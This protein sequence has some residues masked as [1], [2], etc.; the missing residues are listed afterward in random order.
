MIDQ[1]RSVLILYLTSSTTVRMSVKNVIIKSILFFCLF[2]FGTKRTHKIGLIY[3]W[4]IKFIF[5]LF[6]RFNLLFIFIIFISSFFFFLLF[7][8]KILMNN[9]L[10]ILLIHRRSNLC[11]SNGIIWRNFLR[12]YHLKFFY[13]AFWEKLF[14]FWF[15]VL[16]IQ[17]SLFA[18]LILI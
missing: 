16:W 7:M 18:I 9:N 11:C 13:F 3:F 10:N 1:S 12:T 14:H 8:D 5:D 6:L 4:F 2:W 17:Q 15:A